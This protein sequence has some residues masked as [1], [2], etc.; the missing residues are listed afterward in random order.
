MKLAVETND[1]EAIEKFS[2][3]TVKVG[4]TAYD[5]APVYVFDQLTLGNVS[6]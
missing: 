1:V 5:L 3:R 4:H 6:L 2:K